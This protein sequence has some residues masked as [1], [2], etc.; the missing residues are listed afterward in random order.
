MVHTCTVCACPHTYQQPLRRRALS[1][2]AFYLLIRQMTHAWALN[3]DPSMPRALTENPKRTDSRQR[4]LR[5]I[6][7]LNPYFDQRGQFL[8]GPL[9]LPATERLTK[10]RT[11]LGEV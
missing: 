7:E 11:H 3:L 2:E 1:P 5:G 10:L 6:P 4:P 9:E 8:T